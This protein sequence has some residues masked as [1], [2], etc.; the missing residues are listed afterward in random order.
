MGKTGAVIADQMLG[1]L[2]F[3][4]LMGCMRDGAEHKN[5]DQHRKASAQP[6]RG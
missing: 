2:L 6:T 1:L 5:H 3:V 4:V